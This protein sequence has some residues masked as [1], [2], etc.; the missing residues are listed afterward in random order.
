M[1]RSVVLNLSGGVTV[2]LYLCTVMI[3]FRGRLETKQSLYKIN[4]LS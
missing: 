4:L 1:S 3:L 2:G